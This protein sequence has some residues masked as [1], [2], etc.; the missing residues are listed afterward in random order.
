[1]KQTFQTLKP[2]QAPINIEDEVTVN[3]RDKVDLHIKMH[4]GEVITV[5]T[6]GE[7]DAEYDDVR[8]NYHEEK[9]LLDNPDSIEEDTVKLEKPTTKTFEQVRDVIHQN[10]NQTEYERSEWVREHDLKVQVQQEEWTESLPDS[11][12]Q[13]SRKVLFPNKEVEHMTIREE[14]SWELLKE[15]FGYVNISESQ[16]SDQI[17]INVDDQDWMSEGDIFYPNRLVDGID[18]R[19]EETRQ[20]R[21]RQEKVEQIRDEHDELVDVQF[22][23]VRFKDAIMVAENTGEKQR[24]TKEVVYDDGNHPDESDTAIITYYITDT[25]DIVTER[26][27]AY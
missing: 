8:I 26:R 5:E 24:F 17:V 16:F 18:G 22:D 9:I 7:V 11:S 10:K 19:A 3:Y 6:E 2:H 12:Y 13:M 27:E 1:M 23:P 14:A 4:N 20:E 21:E 25:E 15:E